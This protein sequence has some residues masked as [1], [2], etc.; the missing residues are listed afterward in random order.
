MIRTH[1]ATLRTPYRGA[2]PERFSP[3]WIAALDDAARG[4]PGSEAR[5]VIQQVVTS[6][7]GEVAWHVDL[8]PEGVRIRPGRAEAPDVTFTQDRATADAI[9]RGELS[10]A[11]ALTSGRLTVRRRDGP[12]DRAPGGAGPAR[13]R[14]RAGARRCL[15]CPRSG[16]TP[17]A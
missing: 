3:E 17:S 2:V 4:L 1:G 6:D 9:A 8:D 13:R 11:A 16:P 14:P 5:F 12:A 7:D 10:A 15:S